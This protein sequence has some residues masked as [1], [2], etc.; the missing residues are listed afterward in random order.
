MSGK[1]IIIDG[2]YKDDTTV[3]LYKDGQI[4]E[5]RH[6]NATQNFIK[7]NI[8]L[9]K[10]EKIEPALQAAFVNYGQGKSGFLQFSEIHPKYFGSNKFESINKSII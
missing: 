7:G 3:V 9:A 8:Y 1:K 10:I 5:L 4:E 6:Q 2:L